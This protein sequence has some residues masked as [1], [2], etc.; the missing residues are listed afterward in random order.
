HG[1]SIAP[2][3]GGLSDSAAGSRGAASARPIGARRGGGARAYRGTDRPRSG[4]RRAPDP[5]RASQV[6]RVQGGVSGGASLL[7]SAVPALRGAELAK[8]K[9]V[10]GP[11][12]AGRAGDGRSR[13][14]RLPR[15][16]QAA[17][18]RR[19]GDRDDA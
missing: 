14:D 13:Q 18:R 10:G 2:S 4:D 19:G 8:T 11:R 1:H 5:P 3:R 17:P 15:G 16:D 7:R 6:L 12:G 9:P